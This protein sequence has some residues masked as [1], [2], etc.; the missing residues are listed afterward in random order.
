MWISLTILK[1]YKKSLLRINTNLA[2]E[3]ERMLIFT[4]LK[5]LIGTEIERD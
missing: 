4:F 3:K 2:G 1:N 5:Y